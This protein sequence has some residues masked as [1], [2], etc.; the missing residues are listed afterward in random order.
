MKNIIILDEADIISIVAKHYSVEPN[1]VLLEHKKKCTGY[2]PTE[3]M[4]DSV[5]ISVTTGEVKI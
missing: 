4:T 5:E 1:K 2:G 3:S